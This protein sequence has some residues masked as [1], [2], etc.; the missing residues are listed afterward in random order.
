M[1]QIPFHRRDLEC[2]GTLEERKNIGN[3][4]PSK[5]QNLSS[6]EILASQRKRVFFYILLPQ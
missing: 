6:N 2:K 5:I 1:Q 4:M 3:Y